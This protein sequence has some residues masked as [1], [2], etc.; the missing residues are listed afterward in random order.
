M[1]GFAH[2]DVQVASRQDETALARIDEIANGM[3]ARY[4]EGVIASMRRLQS[5]DSEANLSWINCEVHS[6]PIYQHTQEMDQE[7]EWPIDKEVRPLERE[8]V[9]DFFGKK[10]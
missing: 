1:S 4:D 6:W 3:L 5:A 9:A 7:F 2:S 8:R 10:I